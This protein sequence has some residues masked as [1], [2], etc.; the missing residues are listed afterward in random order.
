MKN[1]VKVCV[2]ILLLFDT[3]CAR[4]ACNAATGIAT[5]KAMVELLDDGSLIDQDAPLKPEVKMLSSQQ[6]RVVDIVFSKESRRSS[7]ALI[8]S[9]P[10]TAVAR[11]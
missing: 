10:T 1:L 3:A 5:H 4:L 6:G 2:L 11:M 7:L 9:Q 8:E